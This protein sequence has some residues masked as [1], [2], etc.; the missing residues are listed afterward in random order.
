MATIISDGTVTV[1]NGSKA[2]VFTDG[3]IYDKGVKAG[4][5]IKF[6]GNPNLY[7]FEVAP[8]NNI[9]ATMVETYGKRR[10]G[11]ILILK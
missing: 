9:N 11:H 7:H 10:K 5:W 1:T 8:T 3:K 2:L 4:A 6:D